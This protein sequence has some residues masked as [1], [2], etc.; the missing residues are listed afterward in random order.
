MKRL[1]LLTIVVVFAFS[2]CATKPNGKQTFLG[3]TGEHYLCQAAFIASLMAA[4][5]TQQQID[6]VGPLPLCP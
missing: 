6:L 1:T 5:M 2:G 3:N 4:G